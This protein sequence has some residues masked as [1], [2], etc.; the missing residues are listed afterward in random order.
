MSNPD[1]S[2]TTSLAARLAS[3]PEQTRREVLSGM[4]PAE[5]AALQ[6]CWQLW[7]R[8]DQLPPPGDWRTWLLL[9]GRGSG[10]TR[11]ASEWIRAEV[12]VGRRTQI[13]IIGP[14][15]DS[16][17]RIQVQGPSGIL[18]CAA[19]WCR[20]EFEPSTRRIV[21][22]N[23][24]VCHLFSAE[25]PD[26]LRGPNL[27]AAWCDELT[28]YAD[29]EGVWD[30]LSMALRL[31]GPKGDA[32]QVLITTTP[33]AQPLLKQIIGAS[34]TVVTKSRTADNAANLDASTVR[35]LNER[36]GGTSLGRQELDAELIDDNERAL[37]NRALLERT[38]V[39]TAPA[40]LK[41]VV[42][43]IDP[44]GTANKG[45][46]ETGIVVCALGADGH[47]YVLADLSGKYTPEQWARRAIDAYYRHRADR[48]IAETNFGAGMVE[49]TLRAV[50]R[51]M[52]FKPVTASR[53]KAVRAEPV[54]ALFEQSKAH[55]VGNLT[56]LEDQLCQWEPHSGMS[57]PDRLDAM[58]WGLS[59]LVV[60][61]QPQP[62]RFINFSFMGR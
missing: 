35:Y 24:A 12:E 51:N 16:I 8:P 11:S 18:A 6:H 61:P 60:E 30:M 15:S 50:A 46:D 62:A 52:P 17:R 13:G 59:E 43:S 28:S 5:L 48:I 26:R 53:G 1:P 55:V 58:V 23:G 27:D 32:P 57:S 40:D 29:P 10:K 33:K 25:E 2:A 14:T 36:Y 3:L 54:L 34:S 47:G 21:W 9:G 42:V 41:R 7:A 39:R 37:W 44:A 20:P 38:R 56:E 49:A 31:P 22:P 4:A 19:P 45:S